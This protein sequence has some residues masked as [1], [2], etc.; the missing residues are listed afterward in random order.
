LDQSHTRKG[1]QGVW[2]E[3]AHNM[4]NKMPPDE[5]K[6]FD[7]SDPA[8]KVRM[9]EMRVHT[10]EK[11]K[12]DIEAEA[13]SE[14]VERKKLEERVAKMEKSFQR[15]AGAMIMLPIIGTVIGFV[16]AY[17]KIIFGGAK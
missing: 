4:T 8:F 10:L 5:H 14:Q 9:L 1:H 2:L 15:G 16:F 12:G 13:K 17:G 11:E 3:A 6:A 7:E